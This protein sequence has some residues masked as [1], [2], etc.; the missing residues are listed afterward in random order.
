MRPRF[1]A[2]LSA[3]VLVGMIAHR[4]GLPFW[5]DALDVGDVADMS[6]TAFLMIWFTITALKDP[7]H[8]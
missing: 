5:A 2:S 3:A 8:A 1:Y 7:P 6:L 4:A